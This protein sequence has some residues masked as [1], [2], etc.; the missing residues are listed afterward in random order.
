MTDVPVPCGS[1]NAC[2]QVIG[3]EVDLH[4]ERGEDVSQYQHHEEIQA[5]TGLPALF[6]DKKPNGECVYLVK[7][8]CSIYERRPQTCRQFDCRDFYHTGSRT[9]RHYLQQRLPGMAKVYSAARARMI[10]GKSG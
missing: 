2:C 10:K 3:W 1:C 5:T 4:P 7:G 8:K 9:D 6:L